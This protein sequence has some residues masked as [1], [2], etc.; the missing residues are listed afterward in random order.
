MNQ[1]LIRKAINGVMPRARAT[2]L[3]SSI[4]TF[5]ML[6]GTRDQDGPVNVYIDVPGLV[7]IAC[8]RAAPSDARI[9]A[10]EQKTIGQIDSSNLWHVLLDNYYNAVSVTL[11]DGQ[12]VSGP[13]TAMRAVVD[14]V[15]FDVLGVEPDSQEQMTRVQLQKVTL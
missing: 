13:Q 15:P 4:C 2:G 3:L 8:Q 9:Q 11:P 1:Q 7:G 10:T 12:V 5:Q 6:S 14:G